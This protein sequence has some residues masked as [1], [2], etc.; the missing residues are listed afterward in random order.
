MSRPDFT[1]LSVPD[2]VQRLKKW[3]EPQMPPKLVHAHEK[4]SDAELVAV[5]VLRLLHKQPFFSRW[6]SL[7]KLNFFPGY[8]SLTQ[9][10]VRLARLTDLVERLAVEVEHLDF[11][12]V[13]SQPLNVCRSKRAGRCKVRGAT[14]GY[15]SQGSVYGF[16]LHAWTTPNGKI[17][18]YLIRPANEHD[19]TVGHALNQRWTE[20]GA[21]KQVGDK[22]YQ[23]GA[24][25]TPPKKNAKTPDPRWK[26]EYAAMRHIIETVFSSLVRAG[27]RFAQLKT[28]RSL[29]LRVAFA[30]LA[31]NLKFRYP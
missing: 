5:G 4:I 21:P 12:I 24:F 30:V 2:A 15:G 3:L 28:F 13:D 25:L 20:Y 29:R 11:V 19:L 23:D 9:A 22:A 10:V 31:H 27:I 17:T 18:Q 8:P 7:C 16:K 14:F 1:L 26:E 6:W